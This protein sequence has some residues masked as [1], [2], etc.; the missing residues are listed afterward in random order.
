MLP[1]PNYVY[2]CPK[3][4]NLISKGSL[5]SGN[6]IGAKLY[7]DGKTIAPM[8]PQF[9]NLTKCKKC[10]H[11][12]WLSKNKEIGCYN[13]FEEK[14]LEWRNADVAEFL[15]IDEY[16]S[17]LELNIAENISEERYIRQRIWWAYNDRVRNGDEL[18]NL[19]MIKQNGK[20]ILIYLLNF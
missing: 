1:G 3:C 8:L 9:P 17:A 10:N 20:T 16:F 18:F 7:S 11:I 5:A 15:T 6:T 14:L 4:E 12:F 2:K 19:K 13:D